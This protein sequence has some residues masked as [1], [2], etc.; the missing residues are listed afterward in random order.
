MLNF[1]KNILKVNF[2]SNQFFYEENYT[3]DQKVLAAKIIAMEK[4]ALDKYFK[5]DM[6]GFLD[7]W[8]K[9]NFTYFD[10]NTVK[11][12]DTYEEIA[13]FLNQYIAGKMFAESYD[14]VAPRVQCGKDMAVL[15]YQLHAD[16]SLIEMHYNVIEI[17]Q[18]EGDDWKVI[19]STWDLIT[20]FSNNV[21]KPKTKIVV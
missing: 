3:P 5:G 4:S 20:P 1:F 14:F 13:E 8:S 11:R 16:T 10:A 19:H 7:L 6:S 12:T 15:T 2:M 9:T 18:K 17:F 21:K